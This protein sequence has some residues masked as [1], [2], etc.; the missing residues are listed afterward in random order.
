MQIRGLPVSAQPTLVSQIQ[1]SGSALAVLCSQVSGGAYELVR[2][3]PGLPKNG[4]TTLTG[5]KCT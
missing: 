1:S 3:K 2:R 4:D 5:S